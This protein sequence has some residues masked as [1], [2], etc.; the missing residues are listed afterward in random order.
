MSPIPGFHS[1]MARCRDCSGQAPDLCTQLSFEIL[2]SQPSL[3]TVV[4]FWLL[5]QNIRNSAQGLNYSAQESKFRLL[6]TRVVS[7]PE[8]GLFVAVSVDDIDR[9]LLFLV[10][11][12]RFAVRLGSDFFLGR[13]RPTWLDGPMLLFFGWSC[14]LFRLNMVSCSIYQFHFICLGF[15]GFGEIGRA[16]V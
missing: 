16:H 5:S 7:F 13:R 10:S 1:N 4:S 3:S 11:Q 9:L 8:I 12:T 14:F 6:T 2:I 15:W